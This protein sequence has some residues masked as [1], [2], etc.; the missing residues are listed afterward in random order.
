MEQAIWHL[1]YSTTSKAEIDK[2]L[3]PSDNSKGI[4]KKLI[5]TGIS[6]ESIEKI[7]TIKLPDE[8]YGAYSEKAIKNLL[9]KFH[10]IKYLHFHL[11]TELL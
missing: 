1:L 5:E 8:G 6:V 10:S 2:S 7:K 9:I 4:F 3:S 11:L